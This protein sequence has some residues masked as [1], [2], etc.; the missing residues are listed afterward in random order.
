MLRR[1]KKRNYKHVENFPDSDHLKIANDH[2]EID[3]DQALETLVFGG[4]AT[5]ENEDSTKN[6]NDV[7]QAECTSTNPKPVWFDE[8]DDD[9]NSTPSGVNNVVKLSRFSRKEK[10]EKVVGPTPEWASINSADI[11]STLEIPKYVN[12]KSKRLHADTIDLKRCVDLNKQ[13]QS[14]SRLKAC[15]FHSG[16]QIALTASQ[17][18]RLHLFQVDG[19]TNSKIHSLF[20]DKFQIHCAHFMANGTEIMM[21]SNV[22]WLYSYDMIS[23]KVVKVPYVKGINESKLQKFKVSPCGRYLVFL[24]RCD[25]YVYVS[26]LYYIYK[27]Y[28]KVLFNV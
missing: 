3:A 12:D 19:K 17:D 6:E 22:K 13:G 27:I 1:A 23:G 7:K 5:L 4:L 16:A 28:K 21:S 18:C 2:N 11:E 8:D 25:G 24:S 10:F 26:N 15:E 9:E 14:Q 20:M